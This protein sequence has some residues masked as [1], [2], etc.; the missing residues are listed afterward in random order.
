M[1]IHEAKTIKAAY[2]ERIAAAYAKLCDSVALP[3]DL[4]TDIDHRTPAERFTAEI[5]IAR[6]AR[7]LA[8]K[9]L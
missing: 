7:D 9:L 5:K 6:D 1:T 8:L 3:P 4:Q 2:R